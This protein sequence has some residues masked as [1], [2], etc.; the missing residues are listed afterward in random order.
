M[1]NMIKRFLFRILLK[2]IPRFFSDTIYEWGKEKGIKLEQLK[3]S[4]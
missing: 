2:I 4:R 1:V 3:N